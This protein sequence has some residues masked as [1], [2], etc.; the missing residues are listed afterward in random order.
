[1]SVQFNGSDVE[2]VGADIAL[3]YIVAVAGGYAL[4][5]IA[6]PKLKDD[7]GLKL[8]KAFNDQTTDTISTNSY[9]AFLSSLGVSVS[10]GGGSNDIHSKSI[11]MKKGERTSSKVKI[12]VKQKS[13]L[14]ALADF[15]S[16]KG[17]DITIS[18][19]ATMG[20]KTMLRSSGA[21]TGSITFYI[22]VEV[23]AYP[24]TVGAASTIFSSKGERT[25]SPDL[26]E[27][28]YTTDGYSWSANLQLCTDFSS[29]ANGE[30]VMAKGFGGTSFSPVPGSEVTVTLPNGTTKE[31]FTKW[32]SD[33][34]WKMTTEVK[35]ELKSKMF[36]WLVTTAGADGSRASSSVGFCNWMIDRFCCKIVDISSDVLDSQI[37]LT[38]GQTYG[39]DAD[40]NASGPVCP[41]DIPPGAI[42][43]CAIDSRYRKPIYETLAKHLTA[44][45]F[46]RILPDTFNP[47]SVR[48]KTSTGHVYQFAGYDLTGE[49]AKVHNIASE[50]VKLWSIDPE[51]QGKIRM[52]SVIPESMKR[53]KNGV[54]TDYTT[55]KDLAFATTREDLKKL[56]KDFDADEYLFNAEV[57]ANVV[58]E[59]MWQMTEKWHQTARLTL[60]NPQD[61]DKNF[62]AKIIQDKLLL[63]GGDTED[64]YIYGTNLDMKGFLF[65]T[66][67]TLA[68][69]AGFKMGNKRISFQSDITAREI[70]EDAD[71]NAS[72]GKA[73]TW[74]ATSSL[75]L[76]QVMAMLTEADENGEGA[77][78]ESDFK[79]KL[80]I[81][82]PTITD[83]RYDIDDISFS[84]HF[85]WWNN[86]KFSLTGMDQDVNSWEDIGAKAV[87]TIDQD[88]EL[89]ISKKADGAT[90]GL[91][92]TW[93]VDSK[94]YET[95]DQPGLKRLGQAVDGMLVKSG[96]IYNEDGEPEFSF[97]L[98]KQIAKGI[99][100]SLSLTDAKVQT[101][102]KRSYGE[103]DKG[104]GKL[105]IA[106]TGGFG[107]SLDWFSGSN[108]SDGKN[109]GNNSYES[110]FYDLN[111]N[112]DASGVLFRL[113][114][115]LGTIVY[116]VNS[117]T[118]LSQMSGGVIKGM[119]L[120][121]FVNWKVS[122]KNTLC[123][124]LL[125]L[126]GNLHPGIGG[127][128]GFA[129]H[130]VE[131]EYFGTKYKGFKA[132][133]GIGLLTLDFVSHTRK[134]VIEGILQ[135]KKWGNLSPFPGAGLLEA[136]DFFGWFTDE[137][138]D[139]DYVGRAWPCLV[140]NIINWAKEDYDDE[141]KA[142]VK[143]KQAQVDKYGCEILKNTRG[144]GIT[145]RDFHD[146]EFQNGPESM[147]G[148]YL[149]SI[150]D[151]FYNNTSNS[152]LDR[153]G[154]NMSGGG[155]K[156]DGDGKDRWVHWVLCGGPL[157]GQ[158]GGSVTGAKA[159]TAFPDAGRFP[160]QQSAPFSVAPTLPDNA[161][162]GYWYDQHGA[163]LS[164][165]LVLSVRNYN[166]SVGKTGKT[167]GAWAAFPNM[168]AD[169]TK[170][171]M[172][173]GGSSGYLNSATF[174]FMYMAREIMEFGGYG[175]KCGWTLLGSCK[176]SKMEPCATLIEKW[177]LSQISEKQTSAIIKR[178]DAQLYC[179]GEALTNE[180]EGLT[181]E[182]SISNSVFESIGVGVFK[183]DKL[184]GKFALDIK[185]Y[186][187][188]FSSTWKKNNKGEIVGWAPLKD[189]ESWM[190]AAHE[191]T[192]YQ[193]AT[194]HMKMLS[195]Q[196]ATKVKRDR[197]R[198]DGSEEEC[199]LVNMHTD[200]VWGLVKAYF[201]Y[202]APMGEEEEFV[203]DATKDN[204]KNEP[205]GGMVE[206]HR[207]FYAYN[208]NTAGAKATRARIKQR[209]LGLSGKQFKMFD[210]EGK[211]IDE[212]VLYDSQG[213]ERRRLRQDEWMVD[214]FKD[215]YGNLT[216]E[217]FKH[218]RPGWVYRVRN[219]NGTFGEIVWVIPTR[220]AYKHRHALSANDTP[221][222]S[223]KIIDF[224][225]S[226][227][228]LMVSD[229][230]GSHEKNASMWR[231]VAG[232]WASLFHWLKGTFWGID[233]AGYRHLPW[234]YIGKENHDANAH[235][236]H[237]NHEG[238]GVD[239]IA[240]EEG[241]YK[242]SPGINGSDAMW[243][244]SSPRMN[245]MGSTY[246]SYQEVPWKGNPASLYL[247]FYEFMQQTELEA[248]SYF[249]PEVANSITPASINAF[250]TAK[251]KLAGMVGYYDKS[252]IRPECKSCN[253][254]GVR[255]P[256]D[257]N[258]LETAFGEVVGLASLMGEY[259][260][261]SE[262]LSISL[263]KSLS[264]VAKFTW[265]DFYKHRHTTAGLVNVFD[266]D[267]TTVI[268]LDPKTSLSFD[269][270]YEKFEYIL[271]R[272]NAIGSFTRSATG[273]FRN[274][275]LAM[276]FTLPKSFYYPTYSHPDK[277]IY[278]YEIGEALTDIS[279]LASLQGIVKDIEAVSG[280]SSRRILNINSIQE[281]FTM[282]VSDPKYVDSR[283][284][285]KFYDAV[286]SDSSS[287]IGA[288]S[289]QA[290]I[291]RNNMFCTTGAV[292]RHSMKLV[293]LVKAKAQL[294]A[295]G[296]GVNHSTVGNLNWFSTRISQGQRGHSGITRKPTQND[297]A[298]YIA[299]ERT[300]N[301][302]HTL[303]D[304]ELGASMLGAAN[305]GERFHSTYANLNPAYVQESTALL[306]D[307]FP[308]MQEL[309]WLYDSKS[310]KNL[311]PQGVTTREK[312]A[313]KHFYSYVKSDHTASSH[314]FFMALNPWRLQALDL[315]INYWA[316]ELE[317]EDLIFN[318]NRRLFPLIHE[319]SKL[320]SIYMSS[321]D[322]SDFITNNDK[323]QNA[324]Q[325]EGLIR[326]TVKGGLTTSGYKSLD[327]RMGI[328]WSA[329]SKRGW[330]GYEIL[331]AKNLGEY[332]ESGICQE[333]LIF[334]HRN[335]VLSLLFNCSA[336]TLSKLFTSKG[337]RRKI[338]PSERAKML[339]S[340]RLARLVNS[341]N[342]TYN[343]Y[344]AQILADNFIY[345]TY[346]ESPG[347]DPIAN[348]SPTANGVTN[349]LCAALQ[350]SEQINQSPFLSTGRS[351]RPS[352]RDVFDIGF[353]SFFQEGGLKFYPGNPQLIYP[354]GL[355]SELGLVDVI[356]PSE[357]IP[358][359]TDWVEV[360]YQQ[361][362]NYQHLGAPFRAGGWGSGINGKR[363]SFEGEGKTVT[364]KV[365][366]ISGGF[367]T[368][369][370]K[371]LSANDVL[372]ESMPN[373]T[374]SE[375]TT[376]F[377]N[378]AL[379]GGFAVGV[380]AMA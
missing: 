174:A 114:N 258:T 223:D 261:P 286:I 231:R 237:N 248:K 199:A 277:V 206:N 210:T 57:Y 241:K 68:A 193:G 263:T 75:E 20:Q 70:T 149:A 312:N 2:K 251:E 43:Q 161:K 91:D 63:N 318:L 216:I 179:Q 350:P 168:I 64:A 217:A 211:Q 283:G 213:K 100:A 362:F 358:Y 78:N 298:D 59:T 112:I 42:T 129:F 233:K 224:A 305:K 182:R 330:G 132:T 35:E 126:P 52:I 304:R 97:A 269:S 380:E 98:S 77:H 49:Y 378:Q 225:S 242:Y 7:A 229:V 10:S 230:C 303:A 120:T 158:A 235:V 27:V 327:R 339:A 96:I 205:K 334:A 106:F 372:A 365:P 88:R 260:R 264:Y 187:K 282:I 40:L 246:L 141:S 19:N 266:K 307:F 38:K 92:L 370:T 343:L 14:D 374:P 331:G 319:I 357:Q 240:W 16:D 181:K 130:D 262:S 127:K 9:R 309:G 51:T 376:F 335:T 249:F 151:A 192:T 48:K 214:N 317:Y 292:A 368:Y 196:A 276:K 186:C 314:I 353:S 321:K 306:R 110:R 172:Y 84:Y 6:T 195:S 310:N 184:E 337:A 103:N 41:G 28:T 363:G 203:F 360:E 364:V 131:S 81:S 8:L 221:G 226:G 144:I 101:E 156:L 108:E 290:C 194:R 183:K 13:K 191:V 90:M 136:F 299:D 153:L 128:V 346:H 239:Q 145:F 167:L 160:P 46:T 94:K 279:E 30:S 285:H 82:L 253:T 316:G 281:S 104:W 190:E 320:S 371:R 333:D 295:K 133:I 29:C 122:Y 287:S 18:N 47:V 300:I 284:V 301:P 157:S 227:R 302:L 37:S 65:S 367:S 39:M 311:Q 352:G 255:P 71:G 62:N 55:V 198:L 185:K 146:R 123:Y 348:M 324:R 119:A 236:D 178:I 134:D 366:A 155:Y 275:T 345:G 89:T 177:K 208:P 58:R 243:N 173:V 332:N 171:P 273:I 322:F 270:I 254:C 219:P 1:M 257:G 289:G 25:Q 31:H 278:R 297:Y 268:G 54:L 33:K 5:E 294:F 95:F 293:N 115:N 152:A 15:L 87:W 328:S 212:L 170:W 135:R 140:Y 291:G 150:A 73:F 271:E 359:T 259:H 369:N 342:P 44:A 34:K 326:Q 17:T 247:N 163:S 272:L 4:K 143:A 45:G 50:S 313:K 267:S 377:R 3:R 336:E 121:G 76:T 111:L 197:G 61:T 164:N 66:F 125:G 67:S 26:G 244:L 355:E 288:I 93:R 207:F 338:F 102:I 218:Y 340:P 245:N 250:C 351:L 24:T 361:F 349:S 139:E 162:S 329:I 74:T 341:A 79:D 232:F 166:S 315:F 354:D 113:G 296:D 165:A 60:N 347:L 32:K 85:S 228:S 200:P 323:Y 202:M 180:L 256:L 23:A 308:A 169:G 344:M 189:G 159:G 124:D 274:S 238:K 118:N 209:T 379:A 69:A 83:G 142:A 222:W 356:L 220:T 105:D 137:E 80:Q 373:S 117:R 154:L 138:N 148:D 280:D 107:K 175:Y 215:V 147:S 325:F 56:N 201:T 375:R 234:L 99:N 265:A 109:K 252:I 86:W 12:K 188:N 36:W 53:D 176:H 116:S 72:S 11:E 21:D 22:G 204:G